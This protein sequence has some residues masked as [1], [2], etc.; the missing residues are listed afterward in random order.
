MASVTITG[1]SNTSM[2]VPSA[3]HRLP[4]PAAKASTRPRIPTSCFV[5]KVLAEKNDLQVG[6]I[7]LPA[8]GTTLTVVGIYDA[9]TQFANNGV[10]VSLSALQRLSDQAGSVTTLPPRSTLSTTWLQAPRL[11]PAHSA[12]RQMSRTIRKPPR[13]PSNRRKCPDHLAV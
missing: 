7:R 2:P 11:S 4:G 5:G 10:F 13:Q 3:D 12:T 8:Y 9:G 1:L 6:E